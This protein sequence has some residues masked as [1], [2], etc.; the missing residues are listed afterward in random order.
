MEVPKSKVGK[1]AWFSLS[2]FLI[3]LPMRKIIE[4]LVAPLKN[5]F[6]VIVTKDLGILR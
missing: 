6:I 5:E 1:N 3:I 2:F 4:W